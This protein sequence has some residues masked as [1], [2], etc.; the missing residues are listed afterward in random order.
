MRKRIIFLFAALV[1]MFS[2]QAYASFVLLNNLDQ[3]PMGWWNAGT[4]IGQAFTTGQVVTIDAATFRYDY[5]SYNPTSGAYLTVQN[6]ASD[7]KIGSNILATWN[8]FSV[9]ATER[10]VTYTGTS[11]LA[12]NTTYWLVIHDSIEGYA[13]VSSTSTY[14]ANLGASLPSLYNNYES[15]GGGAYWSLTD[16]PLMFQ[17]SAVPIPAAGWLLGSGLIGLVAVRRRMKK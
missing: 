6:A 11:A 16:G 3:T 13:R 5:G 12:A 4:T 14:T 15:M 10:L 1:F 2:T 7:G 17:V 8:T 9:N